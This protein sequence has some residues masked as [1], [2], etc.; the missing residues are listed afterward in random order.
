M[1]ENEYTM[2]RKLT[3]EYVNRQ[4][5]VKAF[6]IGISLAIIAFLE[7][8]ISESK[9]GQFLM[10]I[11]GAFLLAYPFIVKFI[12]VR[13]LEKASEVLHNGKKEKTQV[14]FN[15]ENIVLN[16]GKVH[17]EH[18]YEQMKKVIQSKNFIIIKTKAGGAV[19]VHKDGFVKG[20]KEAFLEFINNKVQKK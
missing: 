4:F 12:M 9:E 17:L 19:L 5:G 16:E 14:I 20:D 6:V 13:R 1:F 11:L 3:T 8:L 2:D 15:D 18:S 7:A 10:M